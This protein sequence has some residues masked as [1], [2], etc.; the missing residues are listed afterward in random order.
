MKWETWGNGGGG[1]FE[2]SMHA[3]EKS[4]K[5]VD[6]SRFVAFVVRGH[7]HDN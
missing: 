1:G 2:P 4:Q 7:L 5:P 6:A 3:P